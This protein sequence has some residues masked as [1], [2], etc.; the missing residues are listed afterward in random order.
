MLSTLAL[1]KPNITDFARERNE[2]L[3][4]AKTDW[5]L[6]VDTDEELSKELQ[7]EI[8]VAIQ[9]KSCQGFYIKRKIY[10]CGTLAG[11]DKMLRLGKKGA[12]LWKRK[13]HE[14]WDIQGKVRTLNNYIIHNTAYKLTDYIKKVDY[15]ST[16]HAQEV[17]RE[18]KRSNLIKIMLF[19]IGK[20]VVTLVKS[21]HVVFSIMQSLHSYL[22]WTKL[23]FLQH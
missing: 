11:E 15:H 8:D 4:Q 2:L 10:F 7:K 23:Y 9:D 22:S 19:P 16:L 17:L 20:F 14:V 13:V 21:K 12:G 5:V 18:G 6:F 3:K 1:N